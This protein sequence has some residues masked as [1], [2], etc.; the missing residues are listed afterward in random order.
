M[1][2]SQDEGRAFP[3]DGTGGGAAGEGGRA[4][5]PSSQSK[6]LALRL[7]RLHPGA[8]LRRPRS[9]QDPR[10]GRAA[11]PDPAPPSRRRLPAVGSCPPS[12]HGLAFFRLLPKC[13]LMGGPSLATAAS[14]ALL[15][16]L[17]WLL[18]PSFPLPAFLV[19]KPLHVC[20]RSRFS[21]I[22]LCETPWTAAHRA[23]LSTGFSRQEDCSGLPCSPP[24][25]LP[26]PGIE[27]A[28]PTSPALAGRVFTT[29]T[30]WGAL[31]CPCHHLR[32]DCLSICLSSSDEHRMQG[33]GDT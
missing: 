23:P 15:L 19:L 28:S 2:Q 11:S 30:S 4:G 18:V 32:S 8:D 26:G 31:S 13:R 1:C 27:P 5:G 17:P 24:G 20:E 3:G 33:R 22:Q 16:P 10:A 29:N 21:R 6:P 9:V 12:A 7:R 25:D 14:R